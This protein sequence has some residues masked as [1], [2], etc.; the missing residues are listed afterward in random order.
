M[1]Y[2]KFRDI[3]NDQVFGESKKKLLEKIA[4]N[5][6]R[7]VGIFRVTTTKTKIIQNLTQSMEIRF[8]DAF[9]K[10]VRAYFEEQ[11]YKELQRSIVQ[12]KEK[13]LLDQLIQKGKSIIFIEQKIRDD[14]DST[15]K[16]G[17]INNFKEKIK[18]LIQQYDKQQL[19][20]FFWFIDSGIQKNK[21]YYLK[22]IENIQKKYNIRARLVYEKELFDAVGMSQQ[23]DELIEHLKKWRQEIPE[24][25]N[26][27]FDSN[28]NTSFEEIKDISPSVFI[29]LFSHPELRDVLTI[30][31]STGATLEL[32]KTHFQEQRNAQYQQAVQHIDKYLQ[33]KK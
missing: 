20:C 4:E 26:I 27:N 25:P 6:H 33:A 28:P 14:H 5:P 29:K 19:H 7:Y 31:F 17:Q 18:F 13:L 32:L 30:L 8:G 16:K 10:V 24:L 9:E 12:D 2:K 1:Q 11:E 3:F 22:E 23:W 21:N 15:K